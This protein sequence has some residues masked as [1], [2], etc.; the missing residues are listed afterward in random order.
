MPSSIAHYAQIVTLINF[1]ALNRDAYIR[2][3]SDNPFRLA[4]FTRFI[5]HVRSLIKRE[6]PVETDVLIRGYF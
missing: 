6:A 1:R 2:Y 5:N 4:V 3:L